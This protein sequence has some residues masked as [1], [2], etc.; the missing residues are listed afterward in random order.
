MDYKLQHKLK[1]A[2]KF[3]DS[4]KFLHAI[5]IYL[6]LITDF[7]DYPESYISL[8]EIYFHLG[9]PESGEKLLSKILKR[10]PGN[11]E[12]RTY[13]AEY[14]IKNRQWQKAVDLF[15][16]FSHEEEPFASYLIGYSYF[17]LK[18]FELA[19]V[20]LLN[21]VISDEDP[22]LIHSAY[23]LIAQIEMELN[24]FDNALKYAK[25]AGKISTES[26]EYQFV[27]AKT[28]FHLDMIAH[29]YDAV[30][31][32]VKINSNEPE[33]FQLAG[34][35]SFKAK[36]FVN[37]KSYFVKYIDLKENILPSDYINLAN[38]C[39]KSGKPDEA[40]KYVDNAL[41]IDSRN[42]TALA[43]KEKINILL[44]KNLASDVQ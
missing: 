40:L 27:L 16:E 26:W 28:Y 15:S 14:L 30:K 11:I 17:N 10:Q 5:Q 36:D 34:K 43:M 33:I 8:A 38:V 35:I 7:P 29:S 21:F 20:F 31:K 32:A 23:L 37:A 9:K 18:D 25:K 3:E 1:E 6:S 22:E 4:G 39:L 42:K 41:H 24:Q 44:N 2:R 13:L 19:K 12:L